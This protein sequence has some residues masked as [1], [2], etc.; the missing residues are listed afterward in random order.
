MTK[1]IAGITGSSGF[2]GKNLANLFPK[3]DDLIKIERLEGKF[4]IPDIHPDVLLLTHGAVASGADNLVEEDLFA[5]N[6]K[7]TQIIC[8]AFPESNVIFASTASIFGFQNDPIRENSLI[9]PNNDYAISK[10]WA[11]HVVCRQARYSIIR[12]SSLYGNGMRE[13]TIIPNYVNQALSKGEIGVWGNGS[14]KQNYLHIQDAAQ[15]M[16]A[17]SCQS[18]NKIF[19]GVDLLEYSNLEL[20]EMVAQ[21]TGAKIILVGQDSSRS[22]SYNNQFTRDTLNWKPAISFEAGI[23]QYIEWKKRQ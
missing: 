22:V 23:S 7:S 16:L 15:I 20:A 2:L 21:K 4:K 5:G 19:L 10:L 9:L 3:S 18:F 17:A 13:N 12:F 11:E 8:S 6:V 1:E 14:R